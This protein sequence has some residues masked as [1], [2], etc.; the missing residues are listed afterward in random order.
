M[1]EL[2]T[3]ITRLAR[4][5]IKKELEPIKRVNAAQRGLIASLRRDL[6]D[7]Q[8]ENAQLRKDVEK[9]PAVEEEPEDT[10]RF[11]I[12]GRGVKSLRKRLGVT[13]A[14]LGLLA[15]VSMQTVMKWEKTDGKITLRRQETAGLLKQMRGMGKREV[16]ERL[17]RLR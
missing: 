15:N 5:E 4:K 9:V 8:K 2:K 6:T 12:S 11:W 3:E 14:E 16:N 7:L 17:E 10:G 13:L 1:N